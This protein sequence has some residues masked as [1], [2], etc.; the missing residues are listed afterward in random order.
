MLDVKTIDVTIEDHHVLKETSLRVTAGEVVA[1]LGP[2]GSGKTTLLRA[3]AGLADVESGDIT[4]DGESVLG[5]PSHLR[6]F[7]LMF[8]GYALFP[9]MDVAGNVAFGLKMSG[10]NKVADEVTEALEWVDLGGFGDR[11]VDSLSG[12]E[13]QR[14]ALART[15]APR[16]RLVMLDEPLGALDRNLRQRLVIDTRRV[17]EERG[18]T[19]IVVTHDRDEASALADR[20]AIMRDGSVVQTGHIDEILADPA[21]DW[22]ADFLS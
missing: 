7:G 6:H 13:K 10:H 21:D 15:L 5:I 4:W 18:V 1:V 20:L 14:V 3:I 19:S 16:P 9:H 22:V 8:Q 11:A 17:L 12:G 2:S